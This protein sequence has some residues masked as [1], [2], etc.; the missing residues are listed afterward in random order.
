MNLF[1]FIEKEPEAMQDLSNDNSQ[2]Q[3]G[4]LRKTKLTLRQINK[5]RQ[6]NE[7]RSLEF[8]EELKQIKKQ[9]AAP[10]E[11]AA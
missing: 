7:L 8:K 10:A 3:I 1:E 4:Q 11:G 5:L 6:M 2:P 9:Y